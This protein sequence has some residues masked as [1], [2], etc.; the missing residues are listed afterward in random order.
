M[1]QD[2]SETA[3]QKLEY[4]TPLLT[5]YGALRDLTQAGTGIKTENV[6]NCNNGVASTKRQRSC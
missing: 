6:T 3:A 1:A 2:H 4:Q 5:R